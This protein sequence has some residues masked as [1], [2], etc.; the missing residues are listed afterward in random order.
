MLFFFAGYEIDFERIR[1]APLKLAAVGWIISLAIAYAVGGL[2]AAAGIVLSLLFTGSAIATTAIGT[3]IPILGDAGELKTRFGTYLLAAGAIGEFGPII[4]ITL[5]FSAGN[6]ISSALLLLAFIAVAVLAAVLAVRGLGRGW[7]AFTR[8]METSA[9]LPGESRRRAR[10]RARHPCDRSRPRPAARR[11]R[12]RDHH[13]PGARGSRGADPRVEAERDRLRLPDPVLLRR[14]RRR[15]RARCA[16]RQPRASCSSCRSSS[17]RSCSS[18]GSRLC[19]STARRSTPATASRSPSSARPS[20]RWSSRSRRSRSTT[21]RCGRRPRLRW[22]V[23]PSS[24][25]RS[26]R[27]SA[28]GCE[29]RGRA[30]RGSEAGA[31]QRRD[32]GLRQNEVLFRDPGLFSSMW[33]WSMWAAVGSRF[34]RRLPFP[35]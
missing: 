10:L 2:L 33:M 12:R 19:S 26:S 32:S 31:S 30:S 18:A 8:T 29:A 20:C 1:G 25:P 4:L 21:A 22:S 15:V 24:R 14:Q 23:P 27:W 16:D 34:L 11:L 7:E 28:S 13:P 3:L 17:S 6:P 9:Q 5:F 35:L